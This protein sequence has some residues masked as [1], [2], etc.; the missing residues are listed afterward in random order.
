VEQLYAALFGMGTP[1]CFGCLVF[2]KIIYVI[3]VK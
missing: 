3:I 1:K 2:N